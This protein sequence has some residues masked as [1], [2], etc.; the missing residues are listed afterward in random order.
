MNGGPAGGLYVRRELWRLEATTTWDPYTLAY[1]LAVGEMMSKPDD[2][3]LGWVFQANI[4]A[5]AC[6]HGTWYFVSWHRSY[7]YWF[8]RIVRSYVER[9]TDPAPPSDWALPYWNWQANGFLPPAFREQALPGGTDKNPLFTRERWRELNAGTKGLLATTTDWNRA[10]N[11]P[12]FSGPPQFGFGGGDSQGPRH[13]T[14]PYFG[15][16]FEQQPHNQ[17]HNA[18]G[19][20]MMQADSPRDPIFWAHHAMIDRLWDRWVQMPG[21]LNPDSGDWLDREFEFFDENGATVK[22]KASQVLTTDG[23]GYR[24]DDS[25]PPVAQPFPG[26]APRAALAAQQPKVAREP[27]PL[28]ES[29]ELQLV[30]KPG[31][32]SVK[33]TDSQPLEALVA[34]PEE[35]RSVSLVVEGI[36]VEGPPPA[37]YEIYLNLPDVGSAHHHSPQFVGFLD[38]FGLDH[39]E[40]HDHGDHGGTRIYDVTNLVYQQSDDA[41]R[42]EDDTVSVT[43]IPGR[44]LETAGTG[45]A[46]QPDFSRETPHEVRIRQVRFVAE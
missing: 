18:V 22:H 28:G 24:Y 14:G 34:A 23:L 5:D 16:E 9:Q 3:P 26:L 19:G 2:D 39:G 13:F 31:T 1:A 12:T 45:E 11:Q 43:F 6:Q 36:Q 27:Q 29:G 15:G 8:E 46:T 32:V 38:F 7:V 21:H 44:V 10:K 33:L 35:P 25:P 40:G 42:F 4:H 30:N 17:V 41:G 37:P 20:I